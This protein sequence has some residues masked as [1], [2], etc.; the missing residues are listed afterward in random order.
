M[1]LPR[2][3][4]PLFNIL[5]PSLNREVTFRPFVVREEKILLTAQQSGQDKDIILAIKQVIQNCIQDETVNV[6]S[7]A[8]FDLEFIFLKLRSRS[9]NNVVKLAFRDND[10]QKL[11]EFEVDLEEVDMLIP[12]KVDNN[13]KITETAG[14]IMKYPSV[15]IVNSIKQDAT[16]DEVLDAL[17]RNCIKE[18]YDD[19]TVYSATEYTDEQLQDWINDL[20][21]R[22]FER[23][24]EFFEGAPRVYYK[25]EYKNANG[26][27]RVIELNSL[28]DFFTW[29]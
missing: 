6:N 27:E 15:D 19:E 14:I 9:V 13:I 20:D 10:D 7:L 8:I 16:A 22:T 12:A 21:I 18:I 11:Y 1:T 23:V 25:I 17:M 4:K 2:I 5:V 26:D 28:N 29:G 3:D 24:R